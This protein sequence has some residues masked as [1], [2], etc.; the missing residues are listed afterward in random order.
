MGGDLPWESYGGFSQGPK[1]C[2]KSG[3]AEFGFTNKI[4]MAAVSYFS[5]DALKADR[6]IKSEDSIEWA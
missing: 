1:F 3:E 5:Q 2:E 6:T 4:V